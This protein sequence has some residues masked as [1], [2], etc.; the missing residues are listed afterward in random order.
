MTTEK[1]PQPI[2]IVR[3]PICSKPY[4]VAEGVLAPTCGDPDCIREARAR[5]MPFTTPPPN[6]P[7]AP[8]IA[9]KRTRGKKEIL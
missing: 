5:G 8:K 7:A 6:A 4:Q 9:K 2:R 3:C 1:R